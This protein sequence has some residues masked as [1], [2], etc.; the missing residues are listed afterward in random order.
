MKI[1]RG[2]GEVAPGAS[3]ITIGTAEGAWEDSAVLEELVDRADRQMYARR[4]AQRS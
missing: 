1:D 3:R 4:R 2:A